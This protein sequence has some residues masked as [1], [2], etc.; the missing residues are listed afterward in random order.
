MMI[1][2]GLNPKDGLDKE[3]DPFPIPPFDE[4]TDRVKAIEGFRSVPAFLRI[5]PVLEDQ[6]AE[7][8]DSYDGSV[9]KL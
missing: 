4:A 2:S 3:A 7:Y 6:E 1:N 8:Q 9:K 5:E